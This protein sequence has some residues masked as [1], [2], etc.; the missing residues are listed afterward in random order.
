MQIAAQSGFT[1]IEALIYIG[2]LGIMIGGGVV[3]V[4]NI[5]EG[6]GRT[7]ESMYR[8]QDAYFITRKIDAVLTAVDNVEDIEAPAD[9]SSSNSLEVVI[10]GVEVHIIR[11]EEDNQI[12]ILRGGTSNEPLHDIFMKADAPMIFS[13]TADSISAKFTLDGH[14]YSVSHYMP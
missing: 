7:R 8:E 9:G 2:L 14:E 12:R 3:G 13:R 1:L 5:L 6:S 4:Y 10:D 11:D